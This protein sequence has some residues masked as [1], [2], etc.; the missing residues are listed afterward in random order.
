M[1]CQV[2]VVP[3]VHVYLKKT[4]KSTVVRHV[5]VVPLVHVYLKKTTMK[6]QQEYSGTSGGCGT[7]HSCLSEKNTTKY[8]Q[9]Y[10]GT[11]GGCGTTRPCLSEKNTMKYQQ[12]YSGTSGG[13]GTTR[14]CLSEKIIIAPC[15]LERDVAQWLERGALP[16]SLPA[17]RFRIP[18][19]FQRNIM[20]LPS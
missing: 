20:F 12:E 18:Q 3:L 2:D 10:S 13:C 11:S 19:N 14:S 17:V 8:Q 7:T 5:D 15:H 6:Y 4:H 9:E 1:V 16:M